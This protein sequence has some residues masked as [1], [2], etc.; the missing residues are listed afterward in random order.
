MQR[1]TKL[2][3]VEVCTAQHDQISTHLV[4]FGP[5]NCEKSELQ[6][7]PRNTGDE[8]VLKL[9]AHAAAPCQKYNRG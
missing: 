7:W 6:N 9:A 1:D 3:H 8:K 4:N 5:P 2:L